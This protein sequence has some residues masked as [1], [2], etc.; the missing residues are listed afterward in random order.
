M[1][2]NNA[3]MACVLAAGIAAS[4]AGTA[5]AVGDDGGTAAVNGSGSVRAYASTATHRVQ[6]TEFEAIQGIADKPCIGQPIKP[7][8]GSLIGLVPVT[9]HDVN[10]L[11]SPEHSQCIENPS[12]QIKGN[13]LPFGPGLALPLAP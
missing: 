7:N 4:G 1:R 5:A 10:L 9:V 2:I 11:S 3:L 6:S 13:V 12:S 8:T